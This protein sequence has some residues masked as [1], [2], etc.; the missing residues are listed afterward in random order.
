MTKDSKCV[1]VA[2][3]NNRGVKTIQ[4]Y[5]FKS[6]EELHKFIMKSIKAYTGY[7]DGQILFRYNRMTVEELAQEVFIK[8]LRT[9]GDMNK[10]YVRQAVVFVCIDAYRK[11]TEQCPVDPWEDGEVFNEKEYIVL[12]APE[13]PM[14]E[15]LMQLHKFTERELE[16]V[17]LLLEGKRNPEIRNELD[18]P[19][20]TYYT[21]L[22]RIKEKYQ[23]A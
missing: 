14:P 23:D 12:K 21:L 13:D 19:K 2:G 15:R 22:N 5:K 9:V 3:Y 7:Q 6:D 4:S 18:I 10:K 11:N 20:M 8:L 1:K 17:M 16:V